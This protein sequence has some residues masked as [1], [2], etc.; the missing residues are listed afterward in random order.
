MACSFLK[1]IIKKK[2]NH[3]HGKGL[4]KRDKME[5]KKKSFSSLL[6]LPRVNNS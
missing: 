5:N 4:Y 1:M 2:S 3:G 6:P